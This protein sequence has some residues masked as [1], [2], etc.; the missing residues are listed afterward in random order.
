MA[1]KRGIFVKKPRIA[2]VTLADLPL[3]A[4]NGGAVENLIDV[5]SDINELEQCM[6]ISIYS[7]EG[8]E[9]IP[10]KSNTRYFYY[11][12]KHER[13]ISLKSILFKLNGKVIL[14]K[15][16]RN[17]IKRINK[18]K[19]DFVIVTSI[20]RELYD[21]ATASSAPVIWYLH[22]DA[23]EVLG[24][25]WVYRISEK[26][27]AII[28]VSDFVGNRVKDT[29]TN[30]SVHV[31]KNCSDILPLENCVTE[32]RREVRSMA[33]VDEE[34]VFAYVGRIVPIKG[35]L[36]L[37]KAFIKAGRLD[38]KLLIVGES[39]NMNT[40]YYDEV[41][42]Q[43]NDDTIFI[44]YVPHDELNKI[45]CAV[46]V[47]VVPSVCNE[48]A[49][50]AVIEAQR[51][52]KYVIAANKGGI[53][54]YAAPNMTTMVDGDGEVF[55]KNLSKAIQG[56][57]S[58]IQRLCKSSLQEHTPRTFYEDFVKCVYEISEKT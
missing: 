8:V 5:L 24:K 11:R 37:V 52:G 25:E 33:G 13:K 9:D 54:E 22:G 31:V 38:A 15:T 23:V 44:G 4:V 48:A 19:Y 50:L 58:N 12:K 26:C 57:D 42:R 56:Y 17:V 28:A 39:D 18:E 46:D 30:T 6:D 35:V 45:Y 7:I 21:F 16:M 36:E 55:E 14:N 41:R 53:A 49:S 29:G 2:F 47:V 3:P 27:A 32:A 40:D 43:A 34:I 10:Q 51:C 1:I 20:I